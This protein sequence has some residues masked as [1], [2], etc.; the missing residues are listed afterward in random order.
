MFQGSIASSEGRREERELPA[1]TFCIEPFD[2]LLYL[3]N[4]GVLSL[5]SRIMAWLRGLSGPARFL[6]Y[7][8]PATLDDKIARV[9]AEM[10]AQYEAYSPRADLLMGYRRFYEGL[11][12]HAHYQRSQC[13]LVVWSADDPRAIAGGISAAFDTP[14]YPA[15]LPP[16]FEGKYTVQRQPWWHL[17]PVDRPGGRPFWA[18]LTSYEFLPSRWDFVR[19]LE[20]LLNLDFPL[21]LSL[22]ISRTYE[23]SEAVDAI[24]SRITAYQAHLSGTTTEDSRAVQR[25]LDCRKALAEINQGDLLHTVQLHIAIAASDLQMLRRRA[26]MVIHETKAWFRLRAETGLLLNKAIQFFTTKRTRQIDMPDTTWP[27]TSRELAMMYAPVGYRKLSGTRGIMRGE[28]TNG[29]YPYFL[30]SWNDKN[31]NPDKRATHEVWVGVS[32]MGKTFYCNCYLSREYAENGIAFDLLE[33]M[34][35][36]KHVAQALGLPWYVMS[37]RRTKL[38]PQDVMF[39]DIIEQK[40]HV[41][42]IYET[43]LGRQL[44]GTQRANLERGLLGQALETAYRGYGD[45]ATITPDLAPTTDL[46]CDVL[47]GMGGKEQNKQIARDLADEIASLC[48]GTGPFADFL[49]GATNMDLSFRD[50][51]NPRVFSFHEMEGDPILQA[52]AYTQVLSAIRRDSLADDT[53]RIIAV[54]EVY[55]LMRHPSLLDFLIEA[56]KTF[57]TRRKKLI[58]IDQ[59]MS[60]FLQG[61]ARYIFENAPIRV[62]FNQRQ[63]MNVFHEDHAFQHLNEQHLNLIARLLPRQFLLDIQ[64]VGLFFLHN[65]ASIDE[66]ARFHTT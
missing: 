40:S 22:D 14:A 13:A 52:I 65:R 38:N 57:R 46:V 53:P 6:S 33:P 8:F 60:L 28:A 23:F 49:N 4:D 3:T 63:G 7:Q 39:P 62:V 19:P 21:A 47:S 32:G 5:Q 48:C 66:Y 45:L 16:L 2:L 17:A 35:H 26:Q 64:D 51:S 29:A 27:V 30:D 55:R 58:A 42:R 56:A 12:Q 1:R 43:V 34:G 11:N 9:T 59:Q 36:G 50:R 31:G 18:I 24:E 44:T 15:P 37:A 61:K 10:G 20:A 25:I 54:D 41:I